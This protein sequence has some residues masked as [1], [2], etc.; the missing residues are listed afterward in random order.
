MTVLQYL[1]LAAIVVLAGVAVVAAGIG[2]LTLLLDRP[3]DAS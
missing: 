2:L 1:G 3:W